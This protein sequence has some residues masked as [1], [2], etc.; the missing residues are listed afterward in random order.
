[1]AVEHSI[2]DIS[3]RRGGGA[4]RMPGRSW[5][6]VAMGAVAVGIAI[7]GFVPGLA[8]S[9]TRRYGPPT[10]DILLHSLLAAMWLALY[11]T[12]A[13]LVHAGN[14]RIHRRLGWIGIPLA[15][16]VVA[17]GFATTIA[18]GRRGFALWW[19]PDLKI[20]ALADLVHPLGDLFTFSLLISAA[21]IWRRRSDVHK[22]LMLLAAVGSMMA[23]PLIHLMSY[24]PPLRAVPPL[25]LLPLAALYFSSAIHDRLTLGRMHPV[26]KWVG[27]TLLLFAMLRAA[28]IGPSA[29]W[30]QFAGWLIS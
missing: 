25:I 9:P 22:R 29:A 6:Y 2:E 14:T 16:A 11:I 26:S 5:F 8:F 18:Q 20:D 10:T 27:L 21:L 4:Q 3:V 13:V 17:S 24:F 7:I 28:V 30:H 12:Q 1:M 15:I 19:D 23:A